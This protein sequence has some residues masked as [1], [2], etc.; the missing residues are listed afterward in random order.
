MKLD[1]LKRIDKAIDRHVLS[2]GVRQYYSSGLHLF[3]YIVGPM[4]IYMLCTIVVF[5]I[6]G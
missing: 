2:R 3:A 5:G 6:L 1:V 4:D